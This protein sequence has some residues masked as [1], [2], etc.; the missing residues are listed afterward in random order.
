MKRPKGT[1]PPCGYGPEKCPKGSPTAGREL[2]E[3]NWQAW[4]HYQ[5]CAAVGRFPDDE[6]VSRNAGVIRETLDEI[7]RG[8]QQAMRLMLEATLGI[9]R[10]IG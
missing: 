10:T 8:E 6:I 2:T 3:K 1:F 7:D 9:K 5:Q 4:T